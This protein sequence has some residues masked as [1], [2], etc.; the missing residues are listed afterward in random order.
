MNWRVMLLFGV[1]A[2][3]LLLS[4]APAGAHCDD[5]RYGGYNDDRYGGYNDDS[6]GGYDSEY[7]GGGRYNPSYDNRSYGSYPYNRRNTSYDPYYDDRNFEFK[8]D[9]PA[10]LGVFLNGQVGV[11]Q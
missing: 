1:L 4:A 8:R 6:Y 2:T 11:G 9:W 7:R 3:V 10:L 5:D